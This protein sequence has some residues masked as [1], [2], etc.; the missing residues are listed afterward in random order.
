M[1]KVDINDLYVGC[2]VTRYDFVTE[3]F[4]QYVTFGTEKHIYKVSPKMHLYV[5][6]S[7]EDNSFINVR[8]GKSVQP[9]FP[10]SSYESEAGL[11]KTLRAYMINPFYTIGFPLSEKKRLS[12]EIKKDQEKNTNVPAYFMPF[13]EYF[14]NVTGIELKDGF[15]SISKVAILL[16]IINSH[17]KSF[18]LS[19]D[20]KIAEEQINQNVARKK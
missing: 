8:T 2:L 9:I 17:K 3:E 15:V 4:E 7:T 10:N 20:E 19:E 14:K 5:K 16:T 12:E 6:N 18:L 11:G 1:K 13:K